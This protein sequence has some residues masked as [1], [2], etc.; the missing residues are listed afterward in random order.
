MLKINK[1]DC[2]NP[3]S[4]G[5]VSVAPKKT[6]PT[7]VVS[8]SIV[9]MRTSVVQNKTSRLTMLHLTPLSCFLQ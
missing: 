4:R 6:T 3:A 1:F 9:P 7:M 2:V 8:Q 5:L